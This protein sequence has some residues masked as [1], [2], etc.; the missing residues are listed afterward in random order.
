M[1]KIVQRP[2]KHALIIVIMLVSVVSINYANESTDCEIEGRCLEG[3][4]GL[5]P[6]LIEQ[7]PEPDVVPLTYD[8]DMLH[9]RHYQQIEGEVEVY[10][11]PD[12]NVLYKLDAGFNFV[13]TIRS[14]D[15][16]SEVK[17]GH[18]IKSD[19]L[20]TTNHVVSR[21]TGA[22]LPE[23]PMP[24]TMAWMLVNLY[25]SLTPGGPPHDEHP[26]T[27]RYTRVFIY[28]S[29]EIDGWRWYQIGVDKWVHQTQVAKVL[30]VERPE[31]VDTERWISID[32][33]EQVV[34]AYEGD[35][36]VFTTLI[37]SGLPR[38]PTKEGVFNI[39]WRRVRD[40]MTW[41]TPGDDYYFLEEVPWTMF[42][43]E[44][45]ALHGAYW[46]DGFGYRRS[47]GCVNMS[48]TDANWLYNWVAEDMDSMASADIEIGPAV[49]V[50]SSGEY[51]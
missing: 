4:I 21:F 19:K 43:D 7:F 12:G 14:V 2:L 50:Y 30:P 17:T 47:H 35:Q 45:R 51:V 10:D 40:D 33:Y 24:Y 20:T 13:T 5:P 46:H 18:W 34:I 29:V 8:N 37:S 39:Y 15:G 49:Y 36:P 48:I 27:W 3:Q 32:L 1:H 16:W 41:G 25:P 11:G 44:G 23:E 9:D 42:F 38:W 28:D 6:E 26:I 31:D 22:L